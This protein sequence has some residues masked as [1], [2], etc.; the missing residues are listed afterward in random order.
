MDNIG[1]FLEVDPGLGTVIATRISA[2]SSS[3]TEIALKALGRYCLEH[4]QEGIRLSSGEAEAARV[5]TV[6]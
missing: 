1:I 3:E 5:S 6:A 4:G 2:G